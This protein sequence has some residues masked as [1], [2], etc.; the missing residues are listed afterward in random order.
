MANRRGMTFL[1]T[2][3]AVVII[4]MLAAA[5]TSAIS[6]VAGVQRQQQR[7]LEAAEVAHRLI[8]QY[9]DD[10]KEMPPPTQPIGPLNGD[11]FRFEFDEQP[12]E[13]VSAVDINALPTPGVP[14]SN[15]PPNPASG[16]GVSLDRISVIRIRV[17]LAEG[18]GGASTYQP[19][20]P[21]AT[22]TRLFDPMASITRPDT[23]QKIIKDQDR[24]SDLMKKMGG[25]GRSGGRGNTR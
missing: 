2:V 9:I 8:L 20:L 6:F 3:A 1:E 21:G 7:Q 10:P 13:V 19:D 11:A 25:G 22:L 12:V 4:G 24:L 14:G 17:W 5:V 15:A 16:S 18:S 23:G